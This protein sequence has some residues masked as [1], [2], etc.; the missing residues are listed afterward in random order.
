MRPITRFD[1]F[2]DEG[3]VIAAFGKAELV[4]FLNG[5]YELR[6]GSRDDR[7][8]AREWIALFCNDVVVREI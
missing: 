8:E 7:Q 2:K 4:K 5:K 6:G 1:G 3:E